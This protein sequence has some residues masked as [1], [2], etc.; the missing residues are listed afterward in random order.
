[1][2]SEHSNVADLGQCSQSGPDQREQ[3]SFLS[4]SLGLKINKSL[5]A[6]SLEPVIT[7]GNVIWKQLTHLTAPSTTLALNPLKFSLAITTLTQTLELCLC[8][9][10]VEQK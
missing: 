6:E 5:L 7:I 4:N 10:L 3:K 9:S 2:P 1:M 8:E